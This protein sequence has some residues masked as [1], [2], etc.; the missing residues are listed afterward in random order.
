MLK[1]RTSILVKVI[2]GE[3]FER[4]REYQVR[5]GVLKVCLGRVREC[6][7]LVAGYLT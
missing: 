6:P 5:L 2:Y 4:K 7:E 3:W 1:R